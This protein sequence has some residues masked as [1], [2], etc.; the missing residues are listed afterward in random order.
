MTS[1]RR[2][3]ITGLACGAVVLVLIL[4]GLQTAL[5]RETVSGGAF[6]EGNDGSRSIDLVFPDEEQGFAVESREVL[7]GEFLED[8]VRR[9]V[10]EL[11]LGS[12]AGAHPLPPTTRLLDVFFDGDGELVLNFSEELRNDH[13]GGSEAE[14]ASLRCLAGTI[15]ANF[16]AVERMRVLIDGEAIT[17]LAGHVDLA[18][19]LD[20]EDYR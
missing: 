13:P 4:W 10:D 14:L 11:I 19:A 9:T 8:D 1:E 6:P 3:W 7:G 16:P 5:R 2:R 12:T 20:V 17:T 15:A 18:G